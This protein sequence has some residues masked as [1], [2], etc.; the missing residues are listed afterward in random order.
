MTVTI[1]GTTGVSLVQ[2]GVI[3]ANDLAPSFPP[4]AKNK[5]INGAMT[6]AQR[7]T[8][9]PAVA[10]NT[11]TVDRWK[12]LAGN[13][14]TAVVTASLQSDAPSTNE[15]QNSIRLTV[16]TADTSIA[17]GDVWGISQEVEGF[18]VRDLIGKT[19][20]LSFWVRS[21]KTGAHCVSF[22]NGVAD[23]SY[24]AEYSI[25]SANTW[26]FKTITVSGGLIT[27]GTWNWTN[28]TGLSAGFCMASGVT[29]QTAPNA[30]QTGNFL[31]TSNQVNCLDTI[32]NIFAITGVQLEVGPVATNF[33]HRPIGQELALCQRYFER[34]I[35]TAYQSSTA[36]R[37][38]TVSPIYWQ[39]AKRVA[40]E[41]VGSTTIYG[42]NAWSTA[43]TNSNQTFCRFVFT[44]DVAGTSEFTCYVNASAEL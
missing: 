14:S 36:A 5:I 1:N 27:A 6:I 41:V 12:A 22:R 2:D 10:G 40:P 25:L 19:F 44:G 7:G 30:W 38:V 31:A 9:F 34:T 21:S 8:S 26:E 11:Y 3:V 15:F 39:A 42:L 16:T 4:F 23:R 43:F 20:T 28:G 17:A 29:F 33:E 35:A 32:G 24:V 18:N 13:T 37:A